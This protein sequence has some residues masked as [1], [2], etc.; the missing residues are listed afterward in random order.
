MKMPKFKIV[1][2]ILLIA[3][4]I[5]AIALHHTRQEYHKYIEWLESEEWWEQWD[6]PDE[7]KEKLKEMWGLRQS[8][9]MWNGM[10]YIITAG[11]FLF[12]AWFFFI[13]YFLSEKVYPYIKKRFKPELDTLEACHRLAQKEGQKENKRRNKNETDKV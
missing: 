2:I 7:M 1:F 10:P 6:C 5:W 8:W 11:M 13:G 3:T 12:V 4:M 9:W